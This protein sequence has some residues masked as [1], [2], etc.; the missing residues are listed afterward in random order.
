MACRRGCIP[1]SMKQIAG[2]LS[3]TISQLNP[4]KPIK[5]HGCR[6]RL[7]WGY[8]L[9]ATE[10]GNASVFK[11]LAQIL[12]EQNSQ[13]S[14]SITSHWLNKKNQLIISYLF[15]WTW[16][17]SRKKIQGMTRKK[18]RNRFPFFKIHLSMNLSFH[19]WQDR[20]SAVV[21]PPA[22]LAPW[23]PSP[24]GSTVVPPALHL[25]KAVEKWR[26]KQWKLSFFDTG[27]ETNSQNHHSFGESFDQMAICLYENIWRGVLFVHVGKFLR[28]H[29]WCVVIFLVNT[30]QQVLKWLL[31]SHVVSSLHLR[32]GNQSRHREQW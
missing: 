29:F 5:S 4:W 27:D 9:D 2:N 26:W 14:Q 3:H 25:S 32:T 23:A 22:P 8:E 24:V 13:H 20:C 10:V 12:A 28:M 31:S 16:E 7:P 18:K 17:I 30:S 19:R 15:G 6:W 1:P 21:V 11:R